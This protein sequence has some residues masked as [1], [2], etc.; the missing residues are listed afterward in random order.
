MKKKEYSTAKRKFAPEI[1]A[2]LTVPRSRIVDIGTVAHGDPASLAGLQ[3]IGDSVDDDLGEP[4]A[5]ANPSGFSSSWSC[6]L[7]FSL[8]KFLFFC[9]L[10]ILIPWQ[11]VVLNQFFNFVRFL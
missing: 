9:T 2:D 8:F 4:N 1:E 3:R 10:G 5:T 7:P 6:S 11:H